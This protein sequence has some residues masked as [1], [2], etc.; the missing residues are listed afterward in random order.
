MTAAPKVLFVGLDAMDGE[1]ALGWAE[2]G[3]LPA[4]ATL[5]ER[6]AWGEVD[7][8]D[9][10]YVGGLWPSFVT[11]TTPARHGQY[12]WK[13]F[14]PDS[15][16]DL[17]PPYDDGDA[18]PWWRALDR[19]GREVAIVD[20]P[21]TLCVPDSHALQIHDWGTH[22]ALA[23]GFV[24][25]PPE[26]AAEILERYGADPVGVCNRAPRAEARHYRELL[27]RLKRRIQ[28]KRALARD[29]MGRWSWDLFAL[30]FGDA[31]C[32]AHQCWHVHDAS[33]PRHDAAI[34][35]EVGD[36][37]LHVYRALDAAL[38]ELC[39]A[40]GHETLLIVLLSHGV[41][42]HYDGDHLID[43][44]LAR[45]ERRLRHG[46][47]LTLAERLAF[48]LRTRGRPRPKVA[49]R[50]RRW[51]ERAFRKSFRVPN[52]EAFAGIR[53][54]LEGREPH[55]RI[56]P[57]GELDAYCE[58]LE[59]ELMLLRNGA[60]GEPVFLRVERCDR[61]YEGPRLALLPDLLAE[62]SRASEIPSLESPTIGRVE[63]RYAGVRTGDHRPQGLFLAAGAGLTRGRVASAVSVMDFGPTIAARLGVELRDVDGA[64][65]RQLLPASA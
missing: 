45:I 41:G 47:S 25:S 42:P 4:L 14:D 55:G 16:L 18:E 48:A 40:A 9:G 29:L 30:G 33:H 56:R 32:I 43:E 24:T 61:L 11:A 49:G 20:L 2:A 64:P 50:F 8:P 21:R 26:L 53:I 57:G 35:A 39:A 1:L 13:Q 36:P 59:R 15:Y 5:R 58:A 23:P 28:V 12:C 54:N 17:D 38:A 10:F 3:L 46:R 27:A 52:N 7:N 63:G 44:A 65:I 6:A 60:T 19:A 34:A 31:H 22:D 62:W 37:L 51:P